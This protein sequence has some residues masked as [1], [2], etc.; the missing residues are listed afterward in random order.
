MNVT[1]KPRGVRPTQ[2]VPFFLLSA[3]FAVSALQSVNAQMGSAPASFCAW[4]DLHSV[5]ALLS[6][7]AFALARVWPLAVT[8]STTSTTS[9]GANA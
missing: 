5:A 4:Q 3:L 2:S 7:S 6:S 8:S 1:D 9:S